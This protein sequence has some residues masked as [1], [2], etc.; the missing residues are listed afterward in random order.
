MDRERAHL[1]ALP[2]DDGRRN[3]EPE[4]ARPVVEEA[5]RWAGPSQ[6]AFRRATTDTKLA[7]VDIPAGSVLVVSFASVNR[8]EDG[9]PEADRFDPDRDGLQQHLAFGMGKHA[10]IGNP[11]ARMEAVIA[12]QVLAQQIDTLIEAATQHQMLKA[13]NVGG[14]LLNWIAML[15]AIGNRKPDYIAPQMQNGH[16]YGVWRWN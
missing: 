3:S 1:A 5:L 13:G 16:A 10:C 14:E 6:T 9:Y 7:G 8:N 12:I 15:G 4:R 11:L 2:A